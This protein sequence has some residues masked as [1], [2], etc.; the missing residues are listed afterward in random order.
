[1]A[2]HEIIWGVDYSASQAVYLG[3]DPQETYSAII[4]DLGA[5]HIKIH[6]DWNSIGT[7]R[8]E[9]DF[10]SLGPVWY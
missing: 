4:H 1:M 3:L 2:E 8:G 5:K 10:S 7:T 6:I 9:F